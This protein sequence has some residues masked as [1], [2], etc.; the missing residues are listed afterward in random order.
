MLFRSKNK[1][2][3]RL[4]DKS[5]EELFIETDRVKLGAIMAKGVFLG[6][7]CSILPGVTIGAHSN[8]M[9]GSIIDRAVSAKTMFRKKQS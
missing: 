3:M 9:P 4:A 7:N 6:V 1:V 8:A 2:R 5:G